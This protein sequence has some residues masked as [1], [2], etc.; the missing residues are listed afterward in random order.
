MAWPGLDKEVL[1]FDQGRIEEHN[2]A[3]LVLQ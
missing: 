3:L 2:K 1:G